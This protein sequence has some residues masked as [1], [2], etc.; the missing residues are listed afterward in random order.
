MAA[1]LRTDLQWERTDWDSSSLFVGKTVKA[2]SVYQD[3]GMNA[4]ML[5]VVFELADETGSRKEVVLRAVSYKGLPGHYILHT[6]L[7]DSSTGYVISAFPASHLITDVC[8]VQREEEGRQWSCCGHSMAGGCQVTGILFTLQAA[9]EQRQVILHCWEQCKPIP[10]CG[11]PHSPSYMWFSASSKGVS[12]MQKTS[13]LP[14][15]FLAHIGHGDGLCPVDASGMMMAG[16]PRGKSIQYNTKVFSHVKR[17][18]GLGFCSP[19]GPL[20]SLRSRYT[21]QRLMRVAWDSRHSGS[22]FLGPLAVGLSAGKGYWDEI[23]QEQCNDQ[24]ETCIILH[25]VY[26]DSAEILRLP[27]S[28]ITSI[29]LNS[30]IVPSQ[31]EPSP[32]SP[33]LVFPVSACNRIMG[34]LLSKMSGRR[35]IAPGN[36]AISVRFTDG[37]SFSFLGLRADHAAST[38]MFKSRVE[39]GCQGGSLGYHLVESSEMRQVITLHGSAD[40]LISD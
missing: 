6:F 19:D 18:L 8:H 28:R 27:P 3:E 39:A 21:G 38:N 40:N 25:G 26:E 24:P 9:G 12:G 7:S 35:A 37:S 23:F 15:D 32:P 31:R 20:W 5:C 30:T 22:L 4:D 33:A 14:S 2:C 17:V 34:E 13:F 29:E 1:V 11:D 10:F 36:Q 16:G